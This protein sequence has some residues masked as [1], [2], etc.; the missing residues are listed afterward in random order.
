[1]TYHPPGAPVHP[2]MH[3]HAKYHLNEE[4]L[5]QEIVKKKLEPWQRVPSAMYNTMVYR[6]G[7]LRDIY[8][9]TEVQKSHEE[10]RDAMER[11]EKIKNAKAKGPMLRSQLVAEVCAALLSAGSTKGY[12]FHKVADAPGPNSS[13]DAPAP[14]QAVRDRT[15]HRSQGHLSV[16]VLNLGNWERSRK[17][18]TPQCFHWTG[19]CTCGS[20][21]LHFLSNISSDVLLLQ[22]ASTIRQPPGQSH[23]YGCSCLVWRTLE[24][25]GGRLLPLSGGYHW[26]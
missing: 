22:E 11:L 3:P 24:F 4:K 6:A 13:S 19:T 17:R 21:F 7:D 15:V 25:Y 20:L 14:T 5:I 12:A 2:C 18:S 1:M 16:R 8:D 26:R 9:D 23:C 10:R